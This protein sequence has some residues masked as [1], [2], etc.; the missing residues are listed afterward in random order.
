ML[1]LNVV[2]SGSRKQV[3]IPLFNGEAGEELRRAY[4]AGWT[5]YFGRPKEACMDPA[6]AN[7]SAAL[8][9]SFSFDGTETSVTAGEA[10]W[11]LGV[12]E[13]HGALFEGRFRLILETVLPTDQAEWEECLAECAAGKSALYRSC[14]YSAD[15]MLY[16]RDLPVPEELLEEFWSIGSVEHLTEALRHFTIRFTTELHLRG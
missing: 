12:A 7:L 9:D 13:R 3:M 5:R 6:K 4:A 8:Q 10:K 16:G 1:C 14:G 11:Q 2:D 15:Q